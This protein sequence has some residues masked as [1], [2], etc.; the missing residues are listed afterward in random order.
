[1]ALFLEPKPRQL[2]S[3][4][5]TDAPRPTLGMKSRSHAGSASCWLMVG[6]RNPR[7]NASAEVTIPEAPLAPCG[8]PIIDFVYEPGTRCARAPNSCR[9]HRDSTA[10]FSAVDVP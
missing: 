1:M 8:W 6:G 5:A 10:S 2:H 7:D 9:T 4:A 3:A